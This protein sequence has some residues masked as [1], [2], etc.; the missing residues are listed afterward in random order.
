MAS[1]T[2]ALAPAPAVDA[3]GKPATVRREPSDFV[4]LVTPLA[5]LTIDALLGQ[6]NEPP[7]DVWILFKIDVDVDGGPNKDDDE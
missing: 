3:A 4:I 1:D 7:D 5:G 2:K 6:L